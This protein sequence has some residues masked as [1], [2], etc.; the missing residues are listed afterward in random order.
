MKLF[1]KRGGI[2]LS[3]SQLVKLVL[4]G[5]SILMFISLYGLVTNPD[6]F[7]SLYLA[8]DTSLLVSAAQ[9]VPYS[10]HYEYPSLLKER[11]IQ[12]SSDK[13]EVVRDPTETEK[14]F[15]F[16]QHPLLL[17]PGFSLA[18][19]EY[20]LDA[21]LFSLQKKGSTLD[22]ASGLAV[23]YAPVNLEETPSSVTQLLTFNPESQEQNSY[24]A[25]LFINYF[26]QQLNLRSLLS[27]ENTSYVVDITVEEG[28]TNQIFYSYYLQT[29]MQEVAQALAQSITDQTQQAV[30]TAV[31]SDEIGE[32]KIILS[33]NPQTYAQFTNSNTQDNIARGLAIALHGVVLE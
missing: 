33:L 32:A 7:A 28:M 2:Q 9:A 31:L 21:S 18:Q 19:E 26:K 23:K 5:L 15:S 27:E 24:E 20:F 8:R 16:E 14:T 22:F 29:T 1:T 13:V 10:L 4:V 6:A 25:T 12:I 17:F 3:L 11:N 30:G